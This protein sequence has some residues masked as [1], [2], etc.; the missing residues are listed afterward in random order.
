MSSPTADPRTVRLPRADR[1]TES[2]RLP[3]A[4]THPRPRAP[5]T[6]RTCLAAPHTVADAL[7]EY[8]PGERPPVD[9]DATIAFRRHLWSH[10]IGVAEAMDT[11]ERGPGGLTWPQARELMRRS[12]EAAREAGGLVMCGAG[13]EQLT[14]ATPS[15]DDIADAYIEQ[16]AY[17]ED[18]GSAAI[19]RASHA[20]AAVAR[21]PEDYASVYERVLRSA[22]E[23]VI[24]HWL[25]AVFDPSLTGYWGHTGTEDTLEAVVALAK[26]NAGHLRGIKFSLL[27]AEL[28]AE[29]RRRLPAGVEVYTGDDYDY[30]SLILGDG[31]HHSQGLLGVLDPIA[32]VASAA[33]QAL[34]GGDEEGYLRLMGST[35][36]L[37]VRMFEAP[38]ASYK[39]GTVF[40][41]WLGGHQEHFRMVSGRE[42]MRSILH[43][44]D[45]YRLAGDL[46]LFPDP[47][48]AAH[49][50]RSLLTVSGV[51]Q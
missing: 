33:L 26:A 27:D 48:L 2:H 10:G 49:R 9:W 46:G 36:P 18:L 14:A 51:A 11:S 12:V 37:A 20:L 8:T 38:A 30:P 41:A 19:I 5:F 43:L 28:E 4:A 13:T 29:L 40:I 45:L 21:S 23:P 6:R 22:A 17:I 7:A 25:G 35:V 39:T 42:G 50:M 3:D 15:L 16:V 34:D 44:S 47:E 24:V 1:T 32:P 31:V